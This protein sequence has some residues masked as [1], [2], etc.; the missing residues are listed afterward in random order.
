ME[1]TIL[2]QEFDEYNREIYRELSNG[3]YVRWW[4][5]NDD[6][7]KFKYDSGSQL[8]IYENSKG[9]RLIGF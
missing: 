5:L 7:E 1:T 2:K 6:W 9:M 8:E 4:Y 3:D